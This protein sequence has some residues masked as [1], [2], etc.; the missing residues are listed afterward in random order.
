[1]RHIVQQS[2]WSQRFFALVIGINV[3]LIVLGVFIVPS[4]LATSAGVVSL[5]GA[6]CMQLALVALAFVGPGSFQRVRSGIGI[7]TALGALFALVYVGI[8]I[9]EFFGVQDNFNIVWLFVGVPLVAGFTVGYRTRR[10]GQGLLAAI[11]ALVIGTALWSVGDMLVNY[12]FW[13]SHQQYVFWLYDGAIDDFRRSGSA[14]LN[15]FLL[16]DIQGAL[17]YHPILSVVFGAIVGLV[18]SGA[19]LGVRLLQRGFSHAPSHAPSQS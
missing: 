16:Q 7:S 18:G 13:G 2:L 8:I 3:I 4:T 15:A 19:A 17:F 6:I 10:W 5:L 11:W 1:V 9:A 12:V 14:D